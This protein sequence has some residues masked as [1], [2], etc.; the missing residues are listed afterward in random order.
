MPSFC[1]V[2]RTKALPSTT[3]GYFGFTAHAG[4]INQERKLPS[5]R[6]LFVGDARW[7]TIRKLRPKAAVATTDFNGD[8]FVFVVFVVVVVVVYETLRSSRITR[9]YP[10]EPQV[11]LGICFEIM[12]AWLKAPAADQTDLTR[13]H[14]T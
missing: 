9:C 5:A 13:I 2:Q 3:V 11:C 7:S 6:C 12:A 1:F 8:I 10:Y 14:R 4:K